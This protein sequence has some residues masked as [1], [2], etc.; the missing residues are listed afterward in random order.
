MTVE[1]IQL[2]NEVVMQASKPAESE[3]SDAKNTGSVFDAAGAVEV[4]QGSRPDKEKTIKALKE[5]IASGNAECIN[6]FRYLLRQIDRHKHITAGSFI[7]LDR[8]PDGCKTLGDVKAKLNLPDGCLVNN[9]PKGT[10]G[11]DYDK[12]E[13]IAPLSISVDALAYGLGITPDD[14]KELFK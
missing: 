1:R 6:Q 12:H 2:S 5:E 3:K 9:I 7:M 11:G 14:I 13:A 4:T 8:V 10:G